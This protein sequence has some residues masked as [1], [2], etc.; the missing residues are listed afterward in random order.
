MPPPVLKVQHSHRTPIPDA[1]VG[2]VAECWIAQL[3]ATA[4]DRRELLRYTRLVAGID[5]TDF[6]RTLR[7]L[8]A[9]SLI[10]I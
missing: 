3:A 10:H 7:A 6:T 9:L 4:V 2:A 5:G 8:L 1:V